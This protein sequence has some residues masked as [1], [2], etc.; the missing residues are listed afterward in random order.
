MTH[1]QISA[2]SGVSFILGGGSLFWDALYSGSGNSGDSILE[3]DFYGGGLYSGVRNL[4]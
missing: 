3:W 2:I 4:I 1:L